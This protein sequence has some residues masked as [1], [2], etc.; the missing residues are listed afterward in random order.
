MPSEIVLPLSV[1]ASRVPPATYGRGTLLVSTRRALRA[2]GLEARYLAALS[3]SVR[4]QI[5]T[6]I[7]SSWVP[8]EYLLA[9][10]NA[11]NALA[12]DR[13]TIDELGAES[14]KYVFSFLVKIVV[15]LSVQAGATPWT[16]FVNFKRL[17][18]RTWRGSA[19]EVTQLGPK[20]ARVVWYG[21]PCARVPYF[22]QAWGPFMGAVLVPFCTK[23]HHRILASPGDDSTL[24]YR[25]SW[26]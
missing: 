3:P 14:G 20:E 7:A 18:D 9:H 4:D 23:A 13:S 16:V 22:R 6:A 8:A 5:E 19:I 21:Q 24:G 1:P 10:Y 12:L 25:F 2:R 11:C 26:V 15:R 17:L